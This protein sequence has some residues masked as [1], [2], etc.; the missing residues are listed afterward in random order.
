MFFLK[1]NMIL[2]GRALLILRTATNDQ[3][4]LEFNR[5]Q[6]RLKKSSV[7]FFGKVYFKK[8]IKC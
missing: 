8:Q 3:S 4:L 1:L 2:F 7:K 5:N 6:T